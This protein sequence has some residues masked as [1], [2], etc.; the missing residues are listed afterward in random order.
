M[1]APPSEGGPVPGVSGALVAGGAGRRMGADK[2]LLPFAG[3]PLAERALAVLTALFDDVLVVE[4]GGG[5]D[6]RW[7][8]GVRRVTD[9]DGSVPSALN[10]IA[11]ALAHARHP[12]VAV[13]A[14]DLPFPSPDLLRGLCRTA[15]TAHPAPRMVAPRTGK[16]FHPLVAVYH[17]D[18]LG[19]IRE[20]IAG[21]RLRVQELAREAALPVDETALRAWD[22]ELAGLI[23]VNTPEELAAARSRAGEGRDPNR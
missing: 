11:T 9:P 18:L 6:H 3:G 23:N 21:G 17:R 22:P 8:A 14:C 20:R 5:R 1:P 10:G 15:L 12:W 7:P 13:L 19:A 2:A 16:V 4:R